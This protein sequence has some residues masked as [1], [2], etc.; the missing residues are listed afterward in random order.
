MN[1]ILQSLFMN[2]S[3]RQRI[4]N[5]SDRHGETESILYHLQLLFASLEI[6][7]PK[8]HDPKEFTDRLQL[9]THVQQDGQEFYK[10]LIS[11]IEHAFED[12]ED[13]S[14]KSFIRNQFIGSLRY[15]T[16][17]S[18]CG[19]TSTREN[20]FYEIEIPLCDKEIS[21]QESM[22]K[23]TSVEILKDDNQYRC[24]FCNELA[25][26]ERKIEITSIPDVLCFQVMRFGYDT[27]KKSR[28]KLSLPIVFS[29]NLDA[30]DFT[31]T[32][33]D[34]STEYQLHSVLLHESSSAYEGHYNALIRN[35]KTGEWWN[36]NDE[37][38]TKV[39]LNLSTVLETKNKDKMQLL[40]SSA[41]MLVYKRASSKPVETV[42]P[43]HVATVIEQRNCKFKG[44]LKELEAENEVAYRL[45]NEFLEEFKSIWSNIHPITSTGS[46]N[47]ISTEFLKKWI[48]GELYAVKHKYYS[49]RQPDLKFDS[50]SIELNYINNIN[51]EFT[52]QI[53]SE[54]SYKDIHEMFLCLHGN[55]DMYKITRLKRISTDSWNRLNHAYNISPNLTDQMM[56]RECCFLFIKE[57]ENK[58]NIDL[59]RSSFL[60]CLKEIETGDQCFFI[61]KDW[62]KAYR[63]R[64][65]SS[66]DT[67]NESLICEHGGLYPEREKI[68]IINSKA[69][70]IIKSMHPNISEFS[71]YVQKTQG[72]PRRASR[73]TPIEAEFDFEPYFCKQCT[74]IVKDALNKTKYQ[75]SIRTDQKKELMKLYKITPPEISQRRLYKAYC[76]TPKPGIYNIISLEWLTLWKRYIDSGEAISPVDNS[77]LLCEHGKFGYD[78]RMNFDNSENNAYFAI[79]PSEMW[80]KISELYGGGPK[81]DLI[82][83][84]GKLCIDSCSECSTKKKQAFE[85]EQRVFSNEK[86]EMELVNTRSNSKNSKRRT[87]KRLISLDCVCSKISIEVLKL[88]VFESYEIPPNEQ[89]IYYK[90]VLLDDDS[91]TLEDYGVRKDGPW[92]LERRDPKD[93]TGHLYSKDEKDLGFG[94]TALSYNNNSSFDYL[95]DQCINFEQK[96]KKRK[97]SDTTSI[98]DLY[99]H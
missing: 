60:S 44:K 93:F 76:K 32:D 27:D 45:K 61:A 88:M 29:E 57:E 39:G 62:L 94:N 15:E 77:V 86:I 89:D 30:R 97:Y 92:R 14:L 59:N 1:S 43:G 33:N 58:Q 91:K 67:I 28:V 87:K 95:G 84:K 50:D 78:L 48:S 46:T 22:N 96:I 37:Q 26:A 85:H 18:Y 7:L 54:L 56:C 82:V 81:I 19:R 68:A 65:D 34:S 42:V 20:D 83:E 64:S 40:S 16:K 53:T 79:L 4:Y 2:T 35:E 17:C 25:D 5:W 23:Y 49:E 74:V 80:D 10:A 9:A 90:K 24:S 38:T 8:S 36:F 98:E 63:K 99:S 21:I 3:F 13:K 47:W 31:S 66:F 51:H 52:K 72:R 41:Y 6:G 55:I 73:N 71:G 70:E 69:W 12:T 75:A 11:Y